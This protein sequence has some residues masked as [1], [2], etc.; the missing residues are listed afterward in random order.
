MNLLQFFPDC[1]AIEAAP[2]HVVA[3]GLLR[4]LALKS[5]PDFTPVNEHNEMLAAKQLFSRY[6][7]QAALAEA[8][9]WLVAHGMLCHAPEKDRGWFIVTRAGK[10]AAEASDFARWTEDRLLPAELL[11]PVLRSTSLQLFRQE[12]FDHAVFEAFKILEVSTREAAALG[13]D[14]YGQ[15]LFSRAFHPKDGPLTD[16]DA[17]S[18]ERQALMN[19]MVGAYGSFR[20]PQ[21]HRRVG[22][23]AAEAR[24]LLIL[25]SHL[26][27]I[28][29]S[30][31]RTP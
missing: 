23:D 4:I 12:L 20:N 19:L 24:E 26:L 3:G 7:S 25:A 14:H 27:R 9:A 30:R 22:I 21:G 6:E 11:H 28:V 2:V 18:G 16:Q 8:W 29:D 17:D 15:P 10:A 13:D 1:A 31:R 5:K